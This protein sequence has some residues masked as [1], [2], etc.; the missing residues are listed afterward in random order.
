MIA[1]YLGVVV[2][3][4]GWWNEPGSE[5]GG[6]IMMMVWP[7]FVGGRPLLLFYARRWPWR[8]SGAKAPMASNRHAYIVTPSRRHDLETSR[9]MST[10]VA[11]DNL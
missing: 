3:V 6:G 11:W 10:C 7:L 9:L 1:E 5:M 4:P 8:F 2:H